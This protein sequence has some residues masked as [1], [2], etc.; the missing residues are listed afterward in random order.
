MGDFEAYIDAVASQGSHVGKVHQFLK[1]LEQL[2]EVQ[3]TD[4]ELEQQVKSSRLQVRGRIDTVIGDVVFE[5]KTN[6]TKE[7]GDAENQLAKYLAVFYEKAPER[8]CVGIA[9][10]GIFFR[11]YRPVA[12]KAGHC[13]LDLIERQDLRQFDEKHGLL[14]LDRYLFRRAPKQPTEEDI[15][16]RFGIGSPT[17]R[18]ASGALATWWKAVKG[19]PSIALKFELWQRQL[20]IVYGEGVGNDALFL[21]HTYL[22]TLAKLLAAVAFKNPVGNIAGVLTGAHFASIQ[23]H[24]FVEE[25]LFYWMLHPDVEQP[26]T[27]FAERLLE[28]LREYD[29]AGFSEDILKGLY[30]KLVDPEVRH[31]LGEYY[32][33]DWLAESMLRRVASETPQARILD[34]AL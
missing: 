15:S 4:Y 2:F 20:T 34:P 7:L 28:Q 17:Y 13:E 14:W 31:D 30:Q 8:P 10:D 27:R 5:F 12:W 33:P 21:Q 9:T 32:T 29:P 25:D 6:L 24:N 23:I 22:A 3:H 18:V 16:A 1:L 19:E 26:A 11:V